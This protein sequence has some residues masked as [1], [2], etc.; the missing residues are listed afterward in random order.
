MNWSNINNSS[1]SCLLHERKW[2][3]WKIESCTEVE[4]NNLLPLSFREIN[5]LI[6]V[7]NASV[8]NQN[9]NS[10]EL[11]NSF[12]N[13]LLAVSSFSQISKNIERFRVR[14]FSLELT[15]SLFDFLL[16]SKSIEDN[17]VSSCS[18]RVS[19]SKTNTTQRASN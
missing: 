6:N 3:L 16:R 4:C 14:I 18:K 11:F 2:I 8:V 10:T 9:I 13:N 12:I 7:L 1:P 5:A 19:N 15:D 17:I